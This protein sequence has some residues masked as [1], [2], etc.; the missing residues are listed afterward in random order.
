MKTGTFTCFLKAARNSFKWHWF[1]LG[2][3]PIQTTTRLWGNYDTLQTTSWRSLWETDLASTFTYIGLPNRNCPL[4][5]DTSWTATLGHSEMTVSIPWLFPSLFALIS[6]HF[7]NPSM[8]STSFC[9]VQP[10]LRL[11]L[12]IQIMDPSLLGSQLLI[13]LRGMFR[14]SETEA[15]KSPTQGQHQAP[16][17]QGLVPPHAATS[18]KHQESL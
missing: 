6:T 3:R 13:I 8:L 4:I 1:S 9:F 16:L 14:L 17:F 5:I 10:A 12:P 11:R 15:S 2:P 18:C 7:I